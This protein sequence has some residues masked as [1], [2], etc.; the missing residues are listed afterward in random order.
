MSRLWRLGVVFSF[1]RT[2]S[3]IGGVVVLPISGQISGLGGLFFLGYFVVWLAES[4]LL[5]LE[6]A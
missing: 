1:S 6:S 4:I 2:L 5:L 3:Y